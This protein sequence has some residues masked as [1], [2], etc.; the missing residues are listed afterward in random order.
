MT[1][2]TLRRRTLWLTSVVLAAL[3]LLVGWPLAELVRVAVGGNAAAGFGLTLTGDP[4][5]NTI[6]VGLAVSVLTTLLG[7]AAAF[8]TER[9]AVRGVAWLRIGILLPVLIPPF[10]GAMSWMRAYGPGGLSTDLAG[11]ALPGLMGPVGI[12]LVIAVNAAPLAYLLT[13][14]A[15]RTR[16]EADL[17]AAAR[18]SGAGRISTATRITLPLMTTSMLGIAALAF[19]LGINAFG[20]PAVLG[21]P[22]GFQTMTTQI[23]QDLARS[24]RPESFTRAVLLATGLVVLALAFVSIGEALLAESGKRRR[25]SQSAG[26]ARQSPRVGSVVSGLVW[27]LVAVLTV[28]PMLALFLAAISTGVGLPPTPE[29]WTLAHFREILDSRLLDAFGRSILLATLAAFAAVG[30]GGAVAAFRRSRFGR[31]SGAAAL[32]TFA[33]PG[34]TLAVG[35]LLSY[36]S[37][38]RDTLLLILMAYVAKLWAIG[39]RSIEGSA[40]NLPFDL[41][42]AARVSGA[43]PITAFRTVTIPLLAPALVGGWLLVFLIAFHELTMSSLLYG[44]G[45][46]TLAV[47]VLNVQ[48]LG[49]VPAASAMA[50][51]LTLPTVLVAVP[52]FLV[53]RLPPRLVG[54]G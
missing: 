52:L 48:Q 34:S 37:F 31:L 50:M 8:A 51:L 33:V 11:W 21:T 36:G 54:T 12:V 22:A 32:L 4:V 39:H 1:S 25:G 35:M 27:L 28:V 30:L 42:H 15:I 19:V 13:V 5:R 7:M 3:A 23:Y 43:S 26:L 49:D 18:V 53:G 20:V 40:E 45:T 44:P 47:A 10:V 9:A 2:L 46:D 14:A 16:I 6:W 29:T 17:E 41:T 38:L 24:A